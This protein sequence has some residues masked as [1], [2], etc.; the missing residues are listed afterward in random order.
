MYDAFLEITDNCIFSIYNYNYY[1]PILYSMCIIFILL[2]DIISYLAVYKTWIFA[3]NVLLFRDI[4]WILVFETT[5]DVLPRNVQKALNPW[6]AL[7]I[8]WDRVIPGVIPKGLSD[9]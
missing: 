1:Y 4:I 6:V 2:L 3:D 5:L 7:N 9:E 8:L